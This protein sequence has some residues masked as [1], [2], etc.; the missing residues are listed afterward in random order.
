MDRNRKNQLNITGWFNATGKDDAFSFLLF[1]TMC[2]AHAPHFIGAADDFY[3]T[4]PT[5]ATPTT[6]FELQDIMPFGGNHNRFAATANESFFKPNHFNIIKI[7]HTLICELLK[8]PCFAQAGFTSGRILLMIAL[9]GLVTKNRRFGRKTKPANIHCG[10]LGVIVMPSY[11]GRSAKL[12]FLHLIAEGAAHS[13]K[14][15]LFL[16]LLL[17]VTNILWSLQKITLR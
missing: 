6:H 8:L 17:L 5:S 16:L 1:I 15:T 3:F 11:I 4:N 10:L 14:P 7:A 13:Q 12:R 2:F 9:T